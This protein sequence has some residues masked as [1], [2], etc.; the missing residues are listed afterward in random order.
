MG[1]PTGFLEYNR[2]DNSSIAPL[3][4]TA[5]FKEFHNL[6]P[7]GERRTQAARCMNCGV[8]MC[9]SAIKLAGM[10]TGCPLHNLIPE[11]NDALYKGQYF[12]FSGIYG[13]CLPCIVRKG[14][15]LRKRR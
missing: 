14:L 8:P 10:V 4:R 7:E 15:Q 2:K 13:P 6:L 1:K 5:N 12:K 11:W 3:L 9:Q